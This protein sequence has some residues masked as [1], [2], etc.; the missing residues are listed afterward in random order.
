MS[1]DWDEALKTAQD[2]GYDPLLDKKVTENRDKLLAD[3]STSD[4]KLS[5]AKAELTSLNAA[6]KE[7]STALKTF[8]KDLTDAKAIVEDY[9][10]SKA[11]LTEFKAA[12]VEREKAT[13]KEIDALLKVWKKKAPDTMEAL[14][15]FD[16]P[17]DTLAWIKKFG[18]RF[19]VLDE[20]G[21]EQEGNETGENNS[22]ENENTQKSNVAT[23]QP[24]DKTQHSKKIQGYAVGLGG[25]SPSVANAIHK[26]NVEIAN[27]QKK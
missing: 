8:E 4:R 21:A 11:E 23:G 16:K 6:Y 25:V 3:C 22:S 9:E 20:E 13:Q 19:F 15:K 2:K 7:K 1:Y 5:E 24:Q 12:K 27:K 10:S 26:K 18:S 14:P 17:E